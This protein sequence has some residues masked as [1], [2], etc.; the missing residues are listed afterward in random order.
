MYTSGSYEKWRALVHNDNPD[1]SE[2]RGGGK[3]PP[4][5]EKVKLAKYGFRFATLFKSLL[6]DDRINEINLYRTSG[7]KPKYQ[8]SY[9]DYVASLSS[10]ELQ[11]LDLDDG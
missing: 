3:G 7:L 1:F 10:D 4:P 5:Q 11:N 2:R 9:F 6:D 8:K